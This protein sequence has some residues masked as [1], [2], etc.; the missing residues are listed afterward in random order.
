MAIFKFRQIYNSICEVIGEQAAKE[1]FS[2]Y[3]KL[4]ANMLRTV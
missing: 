3:G 4:P 1:L 2:E